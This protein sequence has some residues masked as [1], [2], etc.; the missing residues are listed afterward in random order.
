M[1]TALSQ[2]SAADSAATD[3][4]ADVIPVLRTQI[5]ALDEAL[6]RL[7]A[8]RARVSRRIQAARI[9][10]GGARVE[11]G[12]ERVVHDRYRAALGEDGPELATAVLAI[13][14]GHQG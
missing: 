14:R 8:E 11:L 2:S 4:E 12:R 5:D 7:V 1:T 3:A 13:C 10:S 6:L 9:N